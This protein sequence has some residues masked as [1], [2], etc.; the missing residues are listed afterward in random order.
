[1]VVITRE[2][3]IMTNARDTYK[4]EL[5]RACKEASR[6]RD[7]LKQERIATE[8]RSLESAESRAK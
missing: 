4:K 6:N 1:M 5:E 3:F 2:R 8:L 7:Y